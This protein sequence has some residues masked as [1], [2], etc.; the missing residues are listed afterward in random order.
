MPNL[1]NMAD[2]LTAPSFKKPKSLS[3]YDGLYEVGRRHAANERQRTTSQNVFLE[4]LI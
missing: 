4:L 2:V 3:W 1:V